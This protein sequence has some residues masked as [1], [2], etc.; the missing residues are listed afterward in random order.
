M[1]TCESLCAVSHRFLERDRLDW[2]SGDDI[3]K[4]VK[5]MAQVHNQNKQLEEVTA[6]HTW[7]QVG[8]PKVM[9]TGIE[10]M[11]LGED[12]TKN[13]DLPAKVFVCN[14]EEA[15]NAGEANSATGTEAPGMHW[16]VVLV[17]K[18]LQNNSGQPRGSTADSVS[19]C[20]AEGPAAGS[21][22]AQPSPLPLMR[23]GDGVDIAR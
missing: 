21:S 14:T 7:C 4:A 5:H 16:Y 8:S 15:P 1:T 12:A 20:N 22:I 19:N 6:G 17:W 3:D 9:R 18:P 13:Q 2:L 10:Y 23:K 11:I